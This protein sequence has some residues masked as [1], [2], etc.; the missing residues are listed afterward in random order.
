M[1]SRSKQNKQ[2]KSWRPLRKGCSVEEQQACKSDCNSCMSLPIYLLF[3]CVICVLRQI[4]VIVGHVAN[5]G[6]A[7]WTSAKVLS[8]GFL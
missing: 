5:V 1:N 2:T 4:W 8:E 6:A 3:N 7:S